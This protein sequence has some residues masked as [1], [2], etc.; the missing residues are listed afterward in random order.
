[1]MMSMSNHEKASSAVKNTTTSDMICIQDAKDA[2]R[3]IN[4]A[5][6]LRSRH[7]TP[8]RLRVHMDALAKKMCMHLKD[9]NMQLPYM[10]S[11]SAD[12]TDTKEAARQMLKANK[13][14][15]QSCIVMER[16]LRKVR[17][18]NGTK[19]AN[20]AMELKAMTK[21]MLLYIE[22]LNLECRQLRYDLT[23]VSFSLWTLSDDFAHADKAGQVARQVY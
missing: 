22:D 18:A 3:K 10:S 17:A 15:Q 4:S 11:R 14:L 20:H 16:Q 5:H 23:L 6:M 8:R 13:E 1:M 12:L 2:Q 9:S 7:L 19:A 21:N